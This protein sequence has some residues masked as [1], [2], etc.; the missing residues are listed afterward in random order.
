ML[1]DSLFEDDEI[2]EQTTGEP[3]NLPEGAV[4]A[5]GV[6]NNFAFHGGRLEGHREE[7][8]GMLEEMPLSFF[9]ADKGGSG[10]HSFLALCETREGQIWGQHRDVDQLIVLGVALDM[11]KYLAPRDMWKSLPGGLPYA[12]INLDPPEVVQSTAPT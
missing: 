11:V 8:K 3:P 1:K 9:P 7:I 5:E 2:P 10:G 6:M 12:L 4:I